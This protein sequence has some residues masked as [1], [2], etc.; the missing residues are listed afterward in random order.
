MIAANGV[1]ARYL[2]TQTFPSLRRV[3]R[4]PKR[5]DRIVALAAEHGQT[6][7]AEP[8]AKALEAFLTSAKAADPLRFPDLSLSVIKLLGSGEYV[9]ERPGDRV[10]RP[11]RAGRRGLCSRHRPESPLS[12]SGHA[13]LVEIRAGQGGHAL[14]QR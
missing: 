14:L 8:D 13:A 7:P 12:R 10:G 1:T 6:L 4:T 3:L 11:L 5:W 2:D 9:V